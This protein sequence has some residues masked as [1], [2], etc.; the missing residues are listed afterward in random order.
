MSWH[1]VDAVDDAVDATRRFLFPFSLVRWAKLGLLALFMGGGGASANAS[2]PAASD[3]AGSPPSAVWSRAAR[4]EVDGV[5]AGFGVPDRIAAAATPEILAAGAAG[6]VLLFVAT[7][8]ASLSLRLV[9]YDA[10]RNDEV[11]IV[12]PFLARLRQSV[13]LFVCTAT[14]SVVAA[15][16]V[17]LA[18]GVSVVSDAPT[19]VSA[20]DSAVGAVTSLPTGALAALGLVA[21]GTAA[22][23][24]LALRFTYEFVVPAMVVTDSGVIAGWRRFLPA[25]RVEWADFLV[26]LV[27][28]FVVSVALSVVTGV[29]ALLGFALVATVG[30]L[31]LLLVAA[32]LGGLGVLVGT[33]AGTAAIALVA[34][35][36]VLA[37]VALVLPVQV[38]TLS[39]RFIYEVSTLGSVDPEL[40]LLHPGL[41]A[42]ADESRQSAGE[43]GA[44]R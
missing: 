25:L 40:A 15:A 18:L 41:H 13:G 17:A 10:L 39:Y 5:G 44:G 32:L 37:L 36:G 28:H 11:R 31:V 14:L 29:A 27:V 12:A 34:V 43:D 33:T 21:T 2:L 30:G 4:A 6:L 9:F 3:S 8:V 42:G 26:Y 7:S 22:A 23:A 19:G 38:L 20:V 35:A 24:A 1:A 16:P